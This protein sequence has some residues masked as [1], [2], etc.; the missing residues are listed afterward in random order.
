MMIHSTTPKYRA[1]LDIIGRLRKSGYEAL[2]AGGAVRDMLMG[3]ADDGDIDIAT[4]ARPEIVAR[5][6]SH[7]IPVG[8]KFGVIIVV[9]GGVPFEVATFRSDTGSEDGRHPESVVFTDARTDALRRDFTINGLFYDPLT[10][11]VN[12]YVNGRADISGRIIRAI[13][14][15]SLRFKEDYLRLLRAVRFAA[16]FDFSIDGATWN[17]IVEHAPAIV[18]ISVERIFAELDKMLRGPHADRALDLLYE[19]GLLG[20]VLPEVAALKGVEQPPE[21]HPE[22][23]VFEHTKKALSLL[24]PDP[25]STLVWSLLLHDIG[26]PGTMV[27]ADRLRFNN[28]DQVGMHL[29]RRLLKEFHTSNTLIDDT[30][31][32]IANHMNFMNVK[33]MRLGTLK[34]LL[35]RPTIETEMELHR[36]DCLASHGNCENYEFI[37][38]QLAVFKTE[39][40]KPQPLLGGRDLIAFGFKPGPLFGEIL[41]RLYDLQLEET[42]QTREE[43]IAFV[44]EHYRPS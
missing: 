35:S 1:A 32:C 19:S 2:F 34:R 28:H 21:F 41:D 31:D 36:L 38:E 23:D 43:A 9:M 42:I 15:P 18:H 30:A 40:L 16:R 8:V 6:F 25:S 24:E 37:K 29:A 44:R 10:G 13:G 7:T 4:N 39:S 14:D 3:G 33:R 22:G 5:L 20:L 26:K 12:D 27:K 11:E 17:A